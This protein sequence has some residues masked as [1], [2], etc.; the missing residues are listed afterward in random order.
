VVIVIITLLL[1]I[2]IPRYFSAVYTSQVR[3]CQSQIKIINTA[4]Q[5]F[6]ARNRVWPSRVEDMV[7]GTAP[8]WAV[9]VP[10]DQ[11]PECPFGKPYHLLPELQDGTTGTPTPGNPQ[12]GV[13]V[14]TRDHFD[15]PWITATRHRD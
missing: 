3:S 14:D 1:V 6:F 9:G 11:M 7:R 5:A 12:V 13:V 10:L 4:S 2:A 15:G 8:A